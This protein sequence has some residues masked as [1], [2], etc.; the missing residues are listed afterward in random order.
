METDETD[1]TVVPVPVVPVPVVMS[2]I[3]DIDEDA[4]VVDPQLIEQRQRLEKRQRLIALINEP[5]NIP[6]Q[7]PADVFF[8]GPNVVFTNPDGWSKVI[9]QISAKI[10]KTSVELSQ[11]FV[12]LILILGGMSFTDFSIK[13]CTAIVKFLHE[14]KHL[15]T[16]NTVAF[17]RT[18]VYTAG[19]GY[20]IA[21]ALMSYCW[22]RGVSATSINKIAIKAAE[23]RLDIN[24]DT[25]FENMLVLA[26]ETSILDKISLSGAV[27]DLMC[28]LVALNEATTF[29]MKQLATHATH[30]TI[31]MT[32]FIEHIK[33]IIASK[34]AEIVA[35]FD[36]DDYSV[37]I[38]VE[39][40]QSSAETIQS[41][42][43]TIR[44]AEHTVVSQLEEITT[45]EPEPEVAPE[46]VVTRVIDAM[47]I[48]VATLVDIDNDTIPRDITL[49][50][51]YEVSPLNTK[52]NSQSSDVMDDDVNGGKS[53]KK[54]PLKTHKKHPRKTNKKPRKKNNKK[55]R[56]HRRSRKH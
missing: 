36:N 25:V 41:S 32:D 42:A 30:A 47:D 21:T 34:V 5:K 54:H 7:N 16:V 35:I 38:D 24:D 13:G 14:N 6:P 23:E 44:S 39:T 22:L 31:K 8:A 33:S 27:S 11:S 29:L 17:T 1:D 3:E 49:Q 12:E 20:L 51:G 40:I 2:D 55:S 53:H 52:Q 45:V 56:K 50:P 19:T 48:P 26:D 43:E 37:P 18:V 15:F 10:R 4:P 46:V 9:Y 28:R